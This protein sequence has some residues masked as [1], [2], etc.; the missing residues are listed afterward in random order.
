VLLSR[1]QIWKLTIAKSGRAGTLFLLQ[2]IKMNFGQTCRF[3]KHTSE[4]AQPDDK[5]DHGRGDVGGVPCVLSLPCAYKYLPQSMHHPSQSTPYITQEKGKEEG[6]T[7]SSA[8]QAQLAAVALLLSAMVGG[9]MCAVGDK[10]GA[11]ITASY[12]DKWLEAMATFDG[13]DPRGAARDDHGSAC[14]YKDVDKA[15]FDGMTA[16]GN[17]PI[18]KDGLGCGSCFEIKCKEPAECFDKPVH[19]KITD[20]TTSTSPPTTSTSSARH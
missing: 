9:T 12:D 7:S 19:I 8:R 14:G 17:E 16:C 10:P 6:M 20:R 2:L 11:N 5:L 15:P 3:R 13:S 1:D 18:F 4:H